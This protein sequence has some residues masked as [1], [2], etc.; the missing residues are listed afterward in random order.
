MTADSALSALRPRCLARLRMKARASCSAF[1]FNVFGNSCPSPATG[2]RPRRWSPGHR[3][4]RRR[5]TRRSSGGAR[6]ETKSRPGPSRKSR[7]HFASRGQNPQ[8]WRDRARRFRSVLLGPLDQLVQVLAAAGW[9]GGLDA[10]VTRVSARRRAPPR[11]RRPAKRKRRGKRRRPG[12]KERGDSI[13]GGE[14]ARRAAE[15]RYKCR[16]GLRPSGVESAHAGAFRAHAPARQPRCGCAGHPDATASQR[17][18]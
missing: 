10:D 9:I 2:W 5:K 1:S 17:D 11:R 6:G 16:R 18:S 3:D 14:A 8:E 7:S 12:L 13:A 4:P 15:T